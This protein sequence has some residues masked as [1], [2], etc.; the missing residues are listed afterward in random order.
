MCGEPTNRDVE[1]NHSLTGRGAQSNPTNRFDSVT[2]EPDH[3]DL[4]E[5]EESGTRASRT[6]YSR[7][8]S[9]SIISENNSPDLEFRYSLNP[10]RGCAHGCSYCY[11]RVYHEYLG[12]SAGLDFETKILFKPDAAR[13]FR[14]WL[15][16]RRGPCEPVMLSG[17]TDCY[18]PAEKEF[19]ITRDC[20]EVALA[21]RQPVSIITKNALILSDV[22]LLKQLAEYKLVHV[23]ISLT[24]L[25]QQLTRK[26][27]PRTSSPA[28]RLRA[29]HVLSSVGVPTCAFLAPIIPGLN[30]FEI[31]SLLKA[32]KEARAS[33]AKSTVVRLPGAVESVFLEWLARVVPDKAKLVESRIRHVRG[34]AMYNSSFGSRMTGTGEFASQIRNT[35]KIFSQKYALDAPLPALDTSRFCRPGEQAQLRL[36]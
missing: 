15:R 31:P 33:S 28:A 30:D 16:R 19:R 1:R 26:M 34:G 27:E 14:D 7:D 18:Q 32:A 13:L 21:C 10:Y 2:L 3:S 20:L 17:A 11:A 12:F 9:Q 22:D 4:L 5:G 35:F 6:Q 23:A 8:E 36:F 25:D 24:S 29:I